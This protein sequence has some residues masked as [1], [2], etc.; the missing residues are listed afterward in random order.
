MTDF[1]DQ[2]EAQLPTVT[3]AFNSMPGE[4]ATVPGLTKEDLIRFI[5]SF[6]GLLSRVDKVTGVEIAALAYSNTSVPQHLIN[7]LP[8]ISSQAPNGADHFVQNYL[9]TLLDLRTRLEAATGAAAVPES[10]PPALRKRLAAIDRLVEE[11]LNTAEAASTRSEE[12]E[13]SVETSQTLIAETA[14]KR[15]E[16]EALVSEIEALREKAKFIVEDDA[17]PE[18]PA[19]T[20]IYSKLN[21]QRESVDA[22]VKKIDEAVKR[23]NKS[24]ATAEQLKGNTDNICKDAQGVLD[25]ARSAMRGATQAGLAESF[26]AER[27]SKMTGLSIFGTLLL[28]AVIGAIVFAVREVLPAVDLLTNAV[29]KEDSSIGALSTGLLIRSVLLAPFVFLGWFAAIQYRRID[30]LRIDY[31]AKAAAAKAYVGYKDEMKGDPKLVAALKAH[32]IQRFGEHPVRLVTKEHDE[33][34]RTDLFTIGGDRGAIRP[35]TDNS[36]TAPAA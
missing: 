6:G 27:D 22:Q 4:P 35:P 31:A 15:T 24:A 30:L 32:L 26:I 25:Q 36:D 33:N 19:I 28:I 13:R 1:A 23:A 20:T 21:S 17:D 29:A 12:L 5:T 7:L 14:E 3:Q 16:L 10:A 2:F 18:N 34:V 8:T 9:P 11:G